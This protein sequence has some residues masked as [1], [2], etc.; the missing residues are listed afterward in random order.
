MTGVLAAQKRRDAR[1]QR[2]EERNT[3]QAPETGT[4]NNLPGEL[5]IRPQKTR[6]VE[7]KTPD[8]GHTENA[9][10]HSPLPPFLD[11]TSPFA[12]P[13]PSLFHAER[14][15]YISREHLDVD[16]LVV[17]PSIQIQMSD[18]KRSRHARRKHAQA[19]RWNQDVLPLLIRP[20][21]KFTRGLLSP[22]TPSDD[23]LTVCRCNGRHRSLGV[24]FVSIERL[25]DVVLDICECRTAAVQ[26]VERGFFPC[27]PM[28]PTLAVSLNMLEFVA[29][30]FLH[31]APN[32]RAWSAT[33][34]G[35]LKARG[36]EFATGDSFRRRFS[37]CLAYYQILIRLV[38]AEMTRLIE[39]DKH[40]LEAELDTSTPVHERKYNNS[41]SQP[42]PFSSDETASP[43]AA[44]SGTPGA[45]DRPSEYLRSR[46]PL[47]FGGTH[48][49]SSDMP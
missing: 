28:Y 7:Q 39:N 37:N 15:E 33:V 17:D 8:I 32:E 26:I 46:C 22:H 49:A 3:Q 6:R 47:C 35:Y 27:S 14:S 48:A 16:Y 11:S 29:A 25:E 19:H 34:V 4:Q 24:L 1:K 20:F 9:P 21:M 36:H 30:L 38:N 45:I 44:D 10:G 41:Q 5:S 31:V 23:A 43:S 42:S 13:S 40:G 18:D 12:P 2:R